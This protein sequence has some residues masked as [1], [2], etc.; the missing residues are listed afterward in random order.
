MSNLTVHHLQVSQSERVVWLCEE[1]RIPYTLKLHQRSPLLAPQAIKDLHPLGSAP[2]IQDGSVTLAESAACVEYIIHKHGHKDYASYLYWFH[3]AN[4][5]LQPALGRMMGLAWGGGAVDASNQMVQLG[6]QKMAATLRLVDEHLGKDGNPWLAGDEFT[7]A[8]I[9]TVFSFT[10]MRTFY[11]LDLSEYKNIL[12]YLKRA[13][14][15]EG[16]KEYRKKADPD[17]PLMIDGAAPEQFVDQL[18]KA[19]K[20]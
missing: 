15:R 4:G 10:T 17:L 9:M 13:T 6:K 14:E 7:A 19:G 20:M 12:A 3:F 1:L 11:P 16:Y 2:V 5:T 8:D 18:K